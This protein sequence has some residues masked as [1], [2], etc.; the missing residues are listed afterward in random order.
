[1]N[2]RMPPEFY[3][4]FYTCKEKFWKYYSCGKHSNEHHANDKVVNG[5]MKIEDM[6]DLIKKMNFIAEDIYDL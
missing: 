1:M 4:Y 5:A 3:I 2:R 6:D